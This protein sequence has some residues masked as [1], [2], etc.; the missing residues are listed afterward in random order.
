MLNLAGLDARLSWIGTNI[1]PYTYDVPSLA[2]DNHMICTL[3]DG[4]AKIFLDAT[5][6]Y[7]DYGIVSE[8][9][10]GKQ[11]MIEDESGYIIEQVPVD[12]RSIN[13]IIRTEELLV[14]DGKVISTGSLS[15][16]GQDKQRI[17]SIDN[18]VTIDR[19]EKLLQI[20]VANKGIDNEDFEI[21]GEP[22]IDRDTDLEISYKYITEDNIS[23]F[24]DE[25]YISID[26]VKD[27]EHLSL[28]TTRAGGY[29]FTN[30]T[31]R[32]SIYYLEI[33]DS[34]D[35]TYLP[36]AYDFSH[37]N[38]EFH[39]KY[40]QVENKIIYSN[41]VVYRD[42]LIKKEEFPQWNKHIEALK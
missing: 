26:H 20:I 18:A 42:N 8:R 37:E 9:I 34:Y 29:L 10:Q 4:D 2:V 28:D 5:E 36:K 32:K 7:L 38:Y 30:K 15:I 39:I 16:S 40:E 19:K 11:I 27:Y 14:K 33:P 23:S 22:T 31:L 35:V 1:I 6:K 13:Q 12:N 25:L 24:G 17:L 21:I 41:E 3:I